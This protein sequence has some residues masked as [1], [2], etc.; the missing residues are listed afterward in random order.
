MHELVDRVRAS[1][2]QVTIKASK[3]KESNREVLGKQLVEPYDAERLNK[4]DFVLGEVA[5]EN[6]SLASS[7]VVN[8]VIEDVALPKEGGAC[9]SSCSVLPYIPT[10]VVLDFS[11]GKEGVAVEHKLAVLGVCAVYS[12]DKVKDIIKRDGV[13]R[14]S[15]C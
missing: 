15:S 10:F 11:E 6:G 13:R 14:S 9:S 7:D 4:A 8:I 3:A 12:L 2:K 5:K 1:I